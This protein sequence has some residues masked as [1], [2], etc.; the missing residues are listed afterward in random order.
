MKVINFGS[1]N[2]DHVF[3]VKQFVSPGETMTALGVDRFAG[4]KGLNQS[5][6]MAKAGLKVWH[7]GW[8]GEDGLFLKETLEKNGVET[9]L[10][11]VKEGFSGSAF[12]QVN[13]EGQNCILLNPGTNRQMETTFVNQVVEQLEKEDVLLLQ[14]EVSCIPE[15]IERAYE[16]GVKIAFNPSPIDEALHAYPLDKIHWFILNEIEGEALTGLKEPKEILEALHS[17]YP[18]SKIVLTLGSEGVLYKDQE[19]MHHQLAYKVKPI[20]TTAAGDTFLGYFMSYILQEYT[21]EQALEKATLAASIAVTRQ[22]AAES[23]PLREEVE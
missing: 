8:I 4:G 6:A 13:D 10:V 15:M 16:K 9:Q 5:I 21:V 3:Q 19:K 22:G 7:A 20:D 14:N 23:I 17:K 12:I 1:L 2:C 18:D 11:Q